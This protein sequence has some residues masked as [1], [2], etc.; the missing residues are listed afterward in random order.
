MD[1]IVD[2]SESAGMRGTERDGIRAWTRNLCRVSSIEYRLV[3]DTSRPLQ[4]GG[5]I[6]VQII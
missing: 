5:I 4:E 6:L 3:R 2:A 1:A